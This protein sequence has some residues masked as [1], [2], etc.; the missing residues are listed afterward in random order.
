MTPDEIMAV[1][2]PPRMQQAKPIMQAIPL[3]DGTVR[4]E[5]AGGVSAVIDESDWQELLRNYRWTACRTGTS[6]STYVMANGRVRDGK[7]RR[8]YA[9][10]LVA[11]HHDLL[12]GVDDRRPVHLLDRRPD[13]VVLTWDNLAVPERAE[14]GDENDEMRAQSRPVCQ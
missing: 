7:R 1:F 5:M 11:L 8:L 10:R 3:G 9:H 14:A 13:R 2:P 12:D 4:L 6:P